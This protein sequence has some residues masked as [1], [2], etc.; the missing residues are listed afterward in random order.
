MTTKHLPK[1]ARQH[2]TAGPYSPVLEVDAARIVVISGQVAIDAQGNVMGNDI[3]EQT[4][5]TLANC[6]RQLKS[7]GCGFSEVFKVNVYLADITRVGSLQRRVFRSDA[8][9]PAGADDRRRGAA[10]GLPRRNRNVGGETCM[11]WQELTSRDFH[12]FDRRTPVLLPVAAVEQHG[13]HLP[14]ATDRMIVEHFAGELN[15]R[16]GSARA[17]AAQRA[18]RLLGTPHGIS[19]QPH[20]FAGNVSERREAIPALGVAAR[21]P[22]LSWCSMRTAAIRACARCCSNSLA[23]SIPT[24]RS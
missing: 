11:I 19:R 3:E 8:A 12:D 21:L 23:Q 10:A 1:D 13:P 4:R 22:Q 15:S 14:L 17:R 5:Y 16:L 18:G 20:A 24:A 9:P 7:A 6:Q 2:L